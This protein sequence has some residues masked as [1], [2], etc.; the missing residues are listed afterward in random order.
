MHEISAQADFLDRTSK[1]LRTWTAVQA[2][3][4]Y[5]QKLFSSADIQRQMPDEGAKF[6]VVDDNWRSVVRICEMDARVEQIVQG[7]RLQERLD[8]A[9]ALLDDIKSGML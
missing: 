8:E 5:M 7:D 6:E 4:V 1:L 9:A 2:E 3:W